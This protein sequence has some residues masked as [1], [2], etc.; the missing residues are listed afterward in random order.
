MYADTWLVAPDLDAVPGEAPRMYPLTSEFTRTTA[1]V[2][3]H[4]H[5]IQIIILL[6]KDAL[7]FLKILFNIF[8]MRSESEL[9]L[10]GMIN[11]KYIS[12]KTN[13]L[14]NNNCNRESCEEKADNMKVAREHFKLD[15]PVN[16]MFAVI[17]FLC[18]LLDIK[19]LHRVRSRGL[20]NLFFPP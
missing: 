8:K 10:Q 17:H 20:L 5:G 19:M 11:K 9:A 13:F 6:T 1:F 3:H 18:H 15:E 4:K 2:T 14:K 16:L 12:N 7:C